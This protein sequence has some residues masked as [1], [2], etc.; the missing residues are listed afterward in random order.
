MRPGAGPAAGR[1]GRGK[2]DTSNNGHSGSVMGSPRCGCFGALRALFRRRPSATAQ[3]GYKRGPCG[4]AP[5]LRRESSSVAQR[6]PAAERSVLLLGSPQEAEP[7]SPPAVSTRSRCHMLAGESALQRE[8]S[9]GSGSL[10]GAPTDS[11][12]SAGRHSRDAALNLADAERAAREGVWRAESAAFVGLLSSALHRLAALRGAAALSPQETA[13]AQPDK[14]IAAIGAATAVNAKLSL[15]ISEWRGRFAESEARAR[16]LERQR[17]ESAE[18]RD[19][20]QLSK[21]NDE[22]HSGVAAPIPPSST[23]PSA[24]STVP[25]TASPTC[26]AAAAPT[27]P[28]PPATIERNAAG[29]VMLSGG[30]LGERR[31]VAQGSLGSGTFGSVLNGAMMTPAGA[32]KVAVKVCPL[33]AECEARRLVAKAELVVGWSA[34]GGRDLVCT[35]AATVAVEQGRWFAITIMEVGVPLN[36]VIAGGQLSSMAAAAHG[37]CV[38]RGVDFLHNVGWVHTDIKSSNVVVSCTQA[39]LID[40]DGLARAGDA[41]SISTAAFAPPEVF[42]FKKVQPGWDVWAVGAVLHHLASGRLPIGVRMELAELP[43]EVVQEVREMLPNASDT[44]LWKGAYVRS[45]LCLP[46]GAAGPRPD[47]GLPDWARPIVR[48]CWAREV[49]ER[50][51]A[52]SIL[53]MLE[54]AMELSQ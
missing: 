39:K 13:L 6:S 43:Q 15:E 4:I 29:A 2:V 24:V 1:G 41:V 5:Q 36:R 33:K 3:C 30:G 45:L 27:A 53:R 35:H 49:T 14:N 10:S 38:A 32:L 25:C 51:T 46:A 37:L 34:N 42:E 44:Q 8:G 7:P 47:P 22:S 17:Q 9:A 50:A 54:R 19:P 20:P 16:A 28:T 21:E 11:S 52:A 26:S 18:G 31:A 48:A 40:F 23:S 12:G